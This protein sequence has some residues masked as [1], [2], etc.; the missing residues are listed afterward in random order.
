MGLKITKWDREHS[1]AKLQRIAKQ[2]GK[3]KKKY[4][5][6]YSHQKS[7][8]FKRINDLKKNFSFLSFSVKMLKIF[9][10]Y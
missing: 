7:N 6:G 9:L 1:V 3:S 2:Y 10:V 8:Y 5:L 4:F